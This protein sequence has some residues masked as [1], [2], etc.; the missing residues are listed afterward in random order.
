MEE[1]ALSVF[2]NQSHLKIFLKFGKQGS[3]QFQPNKRDFDL[4]LFSIKT[5]KKIYIQVHKKITF[6]EKAIIKMRHL[7][8]HIILFYE[9]RILNETNK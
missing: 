1:A 6:C 4:R 2:R 3:L 5:N 8:L 7:T 9:N